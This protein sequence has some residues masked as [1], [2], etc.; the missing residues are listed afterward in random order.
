MP[1]TPETVPLLGFGLANYRSFDG[2]GFVL[3]DLKK[4]NVFI[5]KNNCGKSNV[6]RAINVLRQVNSPSVPLK[7]LGPVVDGHRQQDT[8]PVVT[9]VLPAE[10]LLQMTVPRLREEYKQK[11]GAAV[12]VRWNIRT[13][14]IDG[15]HPFE[16]LDL[17]WLQ[18]SFTPLTGKHFSPNWPTEKEHY[19]PDLSQVLI[20]KAV[21]A[22]RGAFPRFLSVP[23]FREFR[24][25]EDP[26]AG[27]H[28]FNGHNVIPRLRLMQNPGLGKEAERQVFNKIRGFVRQLTGE[29][30]LELEVPADEDRILVSLNGTRLPLES[31]GTGIHHLVILCSALAMHERY[32]VTI[33]E[34]EVHLHPELQR[35]FLRFI[36]EQTQN[37]YYITTHSNVFLD[38]LPDVNIYHVRFDGVRS[39][40]E[41]A[42]T[43][44][45][46]RTVLTDMGY[47]A[48]DLLQSNGIIWVE[49]PSDRV[50]LKRWLSL[51]APDLVEGIHYSVAFYGGRVLAHFCCADDPAEDLVE[52][53]RINRHAVVMMDP[54]GDAATAKLNAS[55][56]RILA[57]L[58]Q[59]SCW[60]TQGREIEN[61]LP[62]ALFERYLAERYGT[63]VTV[64][65]SADDRLGD[66]LAEATEGEARKV[67]YDDEKVDYARAFCQLMTEGDLDVLDLREWLGRVIGHIRRWNH[68]EPAQVAVLPPASAK[69]D[70]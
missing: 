3:R 11:M 20:A 64:Q 22:L 67:R 16:A 60:V 9:A 30:E 6:L 23:V 29:P 33:E 43:S 26:S 61:Y 63:A 41:H 40:V 2:E 19:Y 39:T 58:G 56:A 50:Y 53:L 51:L 52:V 66:A 57:E 49:G 15:P 12:W 13:G 69:E 62:K 47:K 42:A 31:Y 32:V 59:G 17:S 21:G 27:E 24:K 10:S 34:P 35:K 45:L 70:G 5:G 7:T 44:P 54:D 37:T 55:K 18:R 25:S 38:A 48:S 36:A 68:L 14:R 4:V 46:A 28:V 1:D 8:P 65:F